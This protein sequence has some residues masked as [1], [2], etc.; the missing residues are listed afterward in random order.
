[1]SVAVSEYPIGIFTT[2][3]NLV[4][5]SWDEWLVRVTG[6][7]AEKAC[8]K[9]LDEL[10]PDLKTRGLLARFQSVLAEG[11]VEVLAPAFHR[12]LIACALQKPSR[13]FSAMQQRVTIAALRERERIVGTMVTIE[14]VTPRLEEERDLAQRLESS[15]EDTRLRA[16]EMLS[17]RNW[18]Q[19]AQPLLGVLSDESWRV[20]RAAVEGLGRRA[21]P[22]ALSA[23]LRALRYEHKNL[24]V[25]NSALQVLTMMDLDTVTPLVEFL[26][27]P[28]VEL[29]IYA[30]LA[31]GE[32]YDPRS[33]P[34]LIKALN[35][36]DPNVRYHAVE[37]LGKL[38][39]SEAVDLLCS[40]IE[41][42]DFY[43]A[44]PAL[45]ALMHIG[46]PRVC[47]RI[48]PLLENEFLREPAAEA[49]G[50]LG[51][52][53]VIPPLVELLNTP[54]AP[55]HIIV[56]SLALLFDRF[57]KLYREGAHI[58]DLTKRAVT[59]AGAMKLI[60][61][62]EHANSEDL[63][64]FVLVLGWLEE[65]AVDRALTRLLGQPA[66]RKEVVEALVRHGNRVTELLIEQ[67]SSED[68]DTRRQAVIALGRIGDVR[69]VEALMAVLKKDE[70]LT[71]VAANALAQI[72]D[73]APFHA[74]LDFLGH[75]NTA[76][77]LAAISALN[78]IGH[79]EMPEHMLR[80]L[81]DEDPVVRDSAVRIAGYFGYAQ[82]ADLL[83]D[84]CRDPDEGVRTTAVEHIVYLDDER[85]METL[86]ESLRGGTP[87]VRGAAARALCH[88]EVERSLPHL[89]TALHDS[90]EWVQYF[91]AR[92]IARCGPPARVECAVAGE[93][94]SA[95]GKLFNALAELT[96]ADSP[97][98]VRIAAVETLGYI[99]GAR[100]ISILAPLTEDKDRNLTR[101]ALESLG[102][103]NTKDAL[104]PILDALHSLD[105]VKRGDAVRA[106]KCCSEKEAV[107]A[108]QWAAKDAD[109]QV[110]QGAIDAL[111]HLATPEA[112]A[113]LVDL[114]ADEMHREASIRAL[115]G[116]GEEKIAYI[117]QG[118]THAHPRV[119]GAVVDAL[120]RMKRLYAT[121]RIVDALGDPEA[122]VRLAAAR[123]LRLLGSRLGEEKLEELA[124]SDPETGVRD[125]A[126][127]ALRA[128]RP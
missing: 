60:D 23:M 40:I 34:A 91:A 97:G 47:S 115:S 72:G 104:K 105:V 128:F 37:A 78:S 107:S 102:H 65:P 24:S 19:S 93:E 8:G 84:R 14:D 13:H 35:D 98:H 73:R 92:S 17:E 63:R 62:L 85:V 41:S 126:R 45:D 90:D 46:D 86:S 71:V 44:F 89:L 109:L 51:D 75:R 70:E 3:T 122:S 56:R 82:C 33:V 25:L 28:D 119:R 31:L 58:A 12:Y 11:V 68:L 67:L 100:A 53:E 50:R 61:A 52:Q 117:A 64:D 94:R 4:I 127:A 66:V 6:I 96:R 54:G 88:V 48:I 80:L 27:E 20:R 32:I 81:G 16:A 59:T 112:V 2:D 21:D 42:G 1:M 55:V 118:L 110:S 83:F 57:Q 36:T 121:E 101:V 38:R 30:A 125:A 103:I 74:L 113:A 116:L 76:V 79:P 10:F 123:A 95:A 108:L 22:D 99:G 87:K 69:A 106:L 124:R 26:R 77:R 18:L 111:G 120:A 29:R 7:S 43:L 39:A 9:A 49:L 114:T 5:R 15:D